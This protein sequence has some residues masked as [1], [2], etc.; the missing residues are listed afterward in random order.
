MFWQ[1]TTLEL[2]RSGLHRRELLIIAPGLDF[3]TLS[4]ASIHLEAMYAHILGGGAILAVTA[5]L[6][7]PL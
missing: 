4:P 7:I 2:Q 6:I 5:S 1:T 3:S